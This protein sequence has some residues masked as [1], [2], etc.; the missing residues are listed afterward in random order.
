MKLTNRR[1]TDFI[2]TKIKIEG[3]EIAVKAGK[4]RYNSKCHLNSVREAM[5]KGDKQIAMVICIS[6]RTEPFIH[7]I[8]IH[9]GKYVDNTLG[10]WKDKYSMFLL[11]TIGEEDFWSIDSMFSNYNKYLLSCIPFYLR[12][13]SDVEF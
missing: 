11:K 7:F 3:T 2:E 4:C 9:K 12:W 1:V 8:N 6:D 13:F 10:V 5:K